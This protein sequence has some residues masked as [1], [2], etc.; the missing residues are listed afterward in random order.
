MELLYL[1]TFLESFTNV[2]NVQPFYG[3]TRF[4]KRI[5]FISL[6]MVGIA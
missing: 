3:V 6:Y 2:Y 1:R 4:L 5:K